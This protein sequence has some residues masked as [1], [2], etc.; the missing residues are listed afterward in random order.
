MTIGST[1]CSPFIGSRGIAVAQ[2]V[3]GILKNTIVLIGRSFELDAHHDDGFRINLT[4][5][6][7][8]LIGTEAVLIVVHPHPMCPTLAV[9]LRADAPLPVVLSHIAATRPTQ[10]GRMQF[11]HGL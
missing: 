1:L 5:E 3:D 7:D 8:E 6:T 4:A 11:L 2:P 9:L 10:A